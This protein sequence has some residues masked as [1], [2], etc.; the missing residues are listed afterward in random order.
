[1]GCAMF[2]AVSAVVIGQCGDRVQRS[3]RRTNIFTSSTHSLVDDSGENLNSDFN[4]TIY[5]ELIEL[6]TSPSDWVFNMQITTGK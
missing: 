5:R 4:E 1:M 3:P 6:Y 2:D